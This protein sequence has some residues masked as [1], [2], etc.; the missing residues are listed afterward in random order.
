MKIYNNISNSKVTSVQNLEYNSP[1][2]K[3]KTLILKKL[4][5]TAW[6]LAS[7]AAASAGLANL[8]L[9][10]KNSDSNQEPIIHDIEPTATPVENKQIV[11]Q[12]AQLSLFHMHDFHGQSVRMERAHTAGEAFE[13]GKLDSESKII[14]ESMP[15]DRLKLCSGDMF[16]GADKERARIVNEFLNQ[17]GIVAT[18]L[19]NHECDGPLSDFAECIKSKNYRIV[20]TNIHPDRTNPITGV[21]SNSFIVEIN[22][23][24]Y[25]IIGASP[26]DF[27]KHTAQPEEIEKLKPDDIEATISEIRE[28]IELIRQNGVNK[29]ILLSHLG[30]D[31]D[32][33]I[34]E[35]VEG[36]DI[37]LGGHTHT[38]FTEVKEGENLFYSP[39]GEPVLIVQSGR[40]GEYIGTPII[41][42][43]ELGQIIEIDYDVIKTDDYERSDEIKE[44]FDK[45]LGKSE[46]LGTIK[47][48]AK[49][50]DDI[51][52]NEN[53]NCSFM[54]DCLR[55]ELGTDIAI[56][57]SASI[58]NRF[59]TGDITSRDL[60]DISPFTDKIVI[61]EATEKEI[62]D[63]IKLKVKETMSDPNHRPGLLQ[64][65][66]LKYK[67]DKI[68]NLISLSF[69]NKEGKEVAINIENPSDKKYTIAVNQY[70]AS[71]SNCG[72]GLKHRVDTALKKFDEDIKDFI[73]SWIK[74]QKE[75]IEICNDGRIS[76]Q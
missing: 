41:K 47:S 52:A 13:E 56:M 67:F 4:P 24:K 42:F 60:E 59:S 66:G 34:A 62:V 7:L 35:K 43:N 72:L 18:A 16:L 2:F 23:N 31:M 22:G 25:G 54:L 9:I 46:K 17:I 1:S 21:V 44:S 48:V 36:V 70:C 26:V 53:P 30:V 69:I 51:Y 65:S 39:N 68:G 5:E 76:R 12:P 38:L 8:A 19:G 49:T 33:Q 29:I 15:T 10:K 63:A 14:D 74:K 64:V 11:T 71:D 55:S 32:K 57:N 6:K 20:G 28:D 58:R 75:P 3:A 73:S 40:D 37:I 27:M 61:I 50:P 45:I